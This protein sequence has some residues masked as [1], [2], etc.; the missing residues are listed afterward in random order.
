M[1]KDTG[2]DCLGTTPGLHIHTTPLPRSMDIKRRLYGVFCLLK[3]RATRTQ[4]LSST[5]SGWWDLQ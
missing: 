1:D 5:L 3:I 4:A 2:N